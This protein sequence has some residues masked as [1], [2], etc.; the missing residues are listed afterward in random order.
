MLPADVKHTIAFVMTTYKDLAP[1]STLSILQ[2]TSM[3]WRTGL[4]AGTL[5]ISDAFIWN[6]FHKIS[7]KLVFQYIASGLVGVRSFELGWISICLGI[8][9]HYFIATVWTATYYEMS[10]RWSLAANRP[11]VSGLTYGLG[12]YLVMNFVV[13]PLSAV[14]APK[15]PPTIGSRIN[16]V[17]AVMFC[18]GL[19][20]ALLSQRK[21]KARIAS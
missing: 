3:I 15:R 20:V 9:L 14:P 12:V 18:I 16:G 4:I 1:R 10:R 2:P 21:L 17:L 5:D 19:T 6:A 8:L 7:P 11:V 13:L